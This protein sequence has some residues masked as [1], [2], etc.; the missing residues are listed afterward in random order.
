MTSLQI[1]LIIGG[2]VLVIGVLIYNWM[3]ERRVRRKMAAAARKPEANVAATREAARVEPRLGGGRAATA[4]SAPVPRTPATPV[5]RPSNIVMEEAR[6]A[7]DF[8]PPLDFAPP[9]PGFDA[10]VPTPE[11]TATAASTM[12]L[13]TSPDAMPQPDPEIESVV[14]LQPV[15]PVKAGALAAGL[16]A[17]LGKQLR[18]FGRNAGGPWHLLESSTTGEWTEVAACLLLADRAGAATKPLIERFIRLV[19]DQATTLAAASVPPDPDTEAVRAEALDRLCADLD[20]QIGLTVLKPAPA[21]IQ[22]TRLRGVAEA[23]GFKLTD[24]GRFEWIPDEGGPPLYSLTNFKSEPFTADTLRVTTT[25]GAVF[26]LDVPRVA[27]P[28]RAFD[29]MKLAAK[30][31]TQTL[32]ATLVDDNRRPLNDT[33]LAAIREQVQATSV[34]LKAI[35][36]DPGSPRALALFGG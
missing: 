34:A 20:V 3:Q 29:Q 6:V 13:Q 25:P 8:V 23:A 11:A 36:V 32:D 33:S 5:P 4:D 24:N 18:W 7:D 22:G 19:S 28:V 17:R 14:I 9:P 12:A 16:H 26:I 31:M 21:T 15:R 30:R 2:V 27:D 35:R 10:P 1:G